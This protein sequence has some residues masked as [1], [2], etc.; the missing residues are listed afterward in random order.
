MTG[1]KTADKMATVDTIILH[2]LLQVMIKS[3]L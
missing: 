3:R 1:A 2:G